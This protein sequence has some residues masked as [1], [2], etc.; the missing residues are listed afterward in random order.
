MSFE[1]PW[2]PGETFQKLWHRITHGDPAAVLGGAFFGFEKRHTIQVER[3][4]RLF[5]NAWAIDAGMHNKMLIEF[6]PNQPDW[7]SYD[8]VVLDTWHVRE[9]IPGGIEGL[10][11]IDRI[12]NSQKIR[13]LHFQTRNRRELADFLE[14][15]SSYLHAVLTALKESGYHDDVIIELPPQWLLGKVESTLGSVRSEIQRSLG[16]A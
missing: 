13:L 9:V 1:G 14:G 16:W 15:R 5:P 8:S 10:Q 7:E 3:F 4:K 2:N 12:I 6:A 11:M